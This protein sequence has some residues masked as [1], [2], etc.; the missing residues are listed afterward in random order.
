MKNILLTGKMGVG[1]SEV[2]KI[3]CNIY[4]Y[5]HYAMADWLKNTIN[6]HYGLVNPKKSDLID[7]NGVLKTY[8][9]ILQ[10]FGTDCIRK[11]DNNWHITELLNSID[12]NKL[13]FVIDDIRFKNEIDKISELYECI[14]I[15]IECDKVERVIRIC[16]RDG[17]VPDEYI[18]NHSSEN[19]LVNGDFS[20]DTT[21]G[22]NNV[23][24]QLKMILDKISI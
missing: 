7:V 23:E 15:N 21:Y 11:F 19:L 3:L 8:R 24:Y 20:I 1:K 17:L 14:V 4:G 9:R 12:K 5:T 6:N 18:N 10:E 13:P 22:Y 2:A 16:R